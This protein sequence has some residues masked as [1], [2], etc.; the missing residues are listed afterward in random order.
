MALTRRLP[1]LSCPASLAQ[2]AH[3]VDGSSPQFQRNVSGGSPLYDVIH[4]IG[5]HLATSDHSAAEEAAVQI[6]EG[7]GA[8]DLGFKKLLALVSQVIQKD[9]VFHQ[10]PKVQDASDAAKVAHAWYKSEIVPLRDRNAGKLDA[11]VVA[12]CRREVAEYADC[13][14]ELLDIRLVVLCSPEKAVNVSALRRKLNQ[15]RQKVKKAKGKANKDLFTAVLTRLVDEAD[16]LEALMAAD[17]K[18]SMLKGLEAF[19]QLLRADMLL[20]RYFSL[21]AEPAQESKPSSENS[22]PLE[23]A[24]HERRPCR[25]HELTPLEKR[26]LWLR[27]H[28]AAKLQLLCGASMAAARASL[29][30]STAQQQVRK[31]D[32]S[33]ALAEMSPMSPH[34]SPPESSADGAASAREIDKAATTKDASQEA[35]ERLGTLCRSAAPWL[36]TCDYLAELE[37]IVRLPGVS[38]AGV[39]ANALLFGDRVNSSST[40]NENEERKK[41]PNFDWWLLSFAVGDA[42]DVGTGNVQSSRTA[43]YELTKAP[44][45]TP[46]SLLCTTLA[47]WKDKHTQDAETLHNKQDSETLHETLKECCWRRF[48]QGQGSDDSSTAAASAAVDA[49]GPPLL[50][51]SSA[52]L[53]P[54]M[55]AP[56]S[57][58]SVPSSYSGFCVED[59]IA[60]VNRALVH[61]YLVPRLLMSERYA[62]STSSPTFL[63]VAV[64][65]C[66]PWITL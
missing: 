27:S 9:K 50:S 28:C 22:L 26:Y 4:G 55:V 37:D 16:L 33:P 51:R 66:L 64:P 58:K 45:G 61:V 62:I 25:Q 18:A 42:F 7:E 52:P 13:L 59:D 56:S 19:N 31:P 57:P 63:R 1:R 21:Q 44:K 65:P 38:F 14:V 15:L 12:N 30:P 2:E 39:F 10:H 29:Q 36:P 8:S 54:P 46:Q 11:I 47:R 49:R 41:D 5:V 17:Y 24:S 32:A 20:L 40:G 6:L 35:Y 23:E 3:D 43:A 53:T 34:S 60:L 48:G